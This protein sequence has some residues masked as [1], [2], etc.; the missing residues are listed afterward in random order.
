MRNVVSRI[1]VRRRVVARQLVSDLV[2]TFGSRSVSSAPSV[3]DRIA[4]LVGRL[5]VENAPVV[6]ESN[7]GRDPVDNVREAF[8]LFFRGFEPLVGS[9]GERDRFPSRIVFRSIHRNKGADG[10]RRSRTSGGSGEKI[11]PQGPVPTGGRIE[12][13]D[14]FDRIVSRHRT[15]SLELARFVSMGTGS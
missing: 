9:L 13:V 7:T 12:T 14:S 15:T 5:V 11:Y 1:T 8:T 6:L 4:E 2:T 10:S 3:R